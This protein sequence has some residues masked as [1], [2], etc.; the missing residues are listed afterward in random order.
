MREELKQEFVDA[1][2]RN[3]R[4]YKF[5]TVLLE[6]ELKAPDRRLEV[7]AATVRMMEG[8]FRQ[9]ASVFQIQHFDSDGHKIEIEVIDPRRDMRKNQDS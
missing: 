2:E 1:V 4:L 8:L 3:I 5:L 7:A 9:I 6:R